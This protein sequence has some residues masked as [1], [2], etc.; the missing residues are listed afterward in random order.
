MKRKH[1]GAAIVVAIV[2]FGFAFYAA[3]AAQGVAGSP[4][5]ASARAAGQGPGGLPGGPSGPGMNGSSANEAKSV[6]VSVAAT[7]TLKPYIDEGG[8]VEAA[9]NVDV[10]PD[11]GGKLTEL[12]VAVGDPVSKGET[13]ALVDPSKPGSS[14]AINAVIAPISG[15]V[16]AVSAEQ[17]QTVS[18][19]TSIAT[20]GIIDRLQVVLNLPERD[21]AKAQKGMSATVEFEALPGEKFRAVV[22]KVSPVVDATSRTKEIKLEFT[23]PD[24][25]IN[26]G[27]YAKVRLYT[28]PL[29]GRIVIPESAIISREDQTFVFVASEDNGTA[30]AKKR[31]VKTGISVD[32]MIEVTQGIE[33]GDKVI[34]DGQDLLSDGT[35]INDVTEGAQ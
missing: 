15:T 22:S 4:S 25:R 32:G 34:C 14:Y 35:K 19:V 27:M 12:K 9:V 30:T 33:V 21:V 23:N 1:I 13:I 3:K 2:A 28:T 26:A 17:G 24:A 6:K 7:T 20:V 8:D 16:T 5:S 29:V 18:T 11:I 31:I 10:Y